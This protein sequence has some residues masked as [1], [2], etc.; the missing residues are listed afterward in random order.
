MFDQKLDRI[1]QALLALSFPNTR[2]ESDILP[3]SQVRFPVEQSDHLQDDP[4]DPQDSTNK[5]MATDSLGSKRTSVSVPFQRRRDEGHAQYVA[6]KAYKGMGH[7]E[8]C[9][10]NMPV[11][12][13]YN[14]RHRRDI[15]CE[16]MPLFPNKA[17]SRGEVGIFHWLL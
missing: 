17:L 16:D 9:M 1:E 5:D 12:E 11:V 2:S 13:C 14:M 3:P 8:P 6:R 10:Y 4:Q 7:Q 15:K